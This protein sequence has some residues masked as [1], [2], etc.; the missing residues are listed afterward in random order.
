MA[1]TSRKDKLIKGT[2]RASVD[3]SNSACL[4]YKVL[5]PQAMAR[6]FYNATH[7][8]SPFRQRHEL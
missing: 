2:Y 6:H 3:T 4:C 5:K 7:T 8:A 1:K